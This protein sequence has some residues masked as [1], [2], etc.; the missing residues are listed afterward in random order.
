MLRNGNIQKLQMRFLKLIFHEKPK[1]GVI[2]QKDSN[3]NNNTGR[4]ITNEI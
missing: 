3:N 1:K 4:K 2:N